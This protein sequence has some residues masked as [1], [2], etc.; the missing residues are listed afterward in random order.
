MFLRIRTIL[1]AITAALV[2]LVL[3]VTAQLAIEAQQNRSASAAF[4]EVN[5]AAERLLVSNGNWAVERGASNAALR[6]K[7]MAPQ[8]ARDEIEKRRIAADKSFAEAF[9]ILTNVPEMRQVGGTIEAARAVFAEVKALRARIDDAFAK[10]IEARSPELIEEV[11]PIFTQL[12]ERTARLRLT[13]ETLVR[14]AAAQMQQLVNMRHLGAEMAEYA[15]R[16][17][18]RLAGIINAKRQMGE[19]D[20]QVL[21][22]GRGH[23]FLAWEAISVL[24]V[25]P[26]TPQ[27][28][29]DAINGV[30]KA[31]IGD[32]DSL[33]KSVIA[34]GS[35]TDYPLSGKDYFDRAT[36]AIDTILLM[37]RALGHVANQ[38][39]ASD[40]ANATTRM[41]VAVGILILG[42]LLA[43]ASFW[44][45]IFRIVRPLT[46][47]T[48]AMRELAAG[49]TNVA[50]PGNGQKDEIGMMAGA[51]QVFKENAI[52]K[53]Q[54]EQ[55]QVDATKAATEGRRRALMEMAERIERETRSA[56]ATIESKAGEV[57]GVSQNMSQFASSVSVD[58]QSVAA[59]SEE[60]LVNAQTVSSAAEELSASIAE[61][62]T[63]VAR[64]SEVTRR[65]VTSGRKAEATIASLTEA[66][67]RI[68]E[69]TRLIGAIAD[70]T[71]L[72]ALNATIESARAGEAGRGFSVVASEVK[73]LA[74][75]TARS[76]AD[77]DRQVADIRT[78]TEAAV[79]AVGEIGHNITEIDEVASA[80]AT[81]MEE[82]EAVTQEIARNV[83]QTAEASREVSAKIQHVSQG[84]QQ[85]GERASEVRHAVDDITGG[86]GELRTVLVR[87][88]RTSTED[89][90]R[91]MAERYPI[92][93]ECNAR[94]SFGSVRVET[95]DVS[96]SGANLRC[97]QPLATNGSGTLALPGVSV[98]ITFIVRSSDRDRANIEFQF[99]GAEEGVYRAWFQSQ[100][101]GL[102]GVG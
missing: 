62:A 50:I 59:A 61:I 32:Y 76:T 95:Q 86:I 96:E 48:N 70:Q 100:I 47:M 85:V 31:Y 2:V 42:V 10:P 82:Q 54:L 79:A 67:A 14:P 58:T 97:G 34:A 60:A 83:S 55:E 25:R 45:A 11:V 35:S 4:V 90:N 20:S 19:R 72:L 7:T 43:A 17:R 84:A 51:V 36:A 75:Q 33:R 46:A 53:A 6:A 99:S 74:N 94:M 80:I 73:N 56:V 89:A 3:A 71:N 69:V 12:I 77:I 78:A 63:Q 38:A 29:V 41:I 26:D 27:E 93:I 1:P 64:A 5:H 22:E 102:R 98:P 37:N 39:A 81:A 23:I 57:G 40:A 91:R 66:V 101:K 18:A 92:R 68:S 28:L 8:S 13:L 16:E 52:A 15:G 24:R 21:A 9:E 87:V 88:V 65:A 30:E 44:I 49:R